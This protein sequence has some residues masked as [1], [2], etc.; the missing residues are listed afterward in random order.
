M[1]AHKLCWEAGWQLSFPCSWRKPGTC[2]SFPDF[3]NWALGVA[4][5]RP[6]NNQRSHAP[7]HPP[8][9]QV[10]NV[11]DTTPRDQLDKMKSICRVV[12][13]RRKP[14]PPSWLCR[15]S[16]AWVVPKE[17]TALPQTRRTHALRAVPFPLVLSRLMSGWRLGIHAL[18]TASTS[19]SSCCP[20]NATFPAISIPISHFLDAG[21]STKFCRGAGTRMC[22]GPPWLGTHPDTHGHTEKSRDPDGILLQETAM[23][24]VMQP[25]FRQ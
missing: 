3:R 8:H 15:H 23:P 1:P 25:V 6:S 20:G 21:H 24:W 12:M 18:I 4:T 5:W 10:T 14:L 19:T 11:C 17:L 22:D 7:W 13:S 2:S 16:L 9:L